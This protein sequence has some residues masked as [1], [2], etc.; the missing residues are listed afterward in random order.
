MVLLSDD[1]ICNMTSKF[2]GNTGTQTGCFK[3]EGD[4]GFGVVESTRD[5]YPGGQREQWN[6]GPDVVE[7]VGNKG[8]GS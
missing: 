5:K 6:K 2:Q 4:M 1:N 3:R 7:D 8:P